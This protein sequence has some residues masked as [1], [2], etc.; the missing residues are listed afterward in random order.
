MRV[1]IVA[2]YVAL[3]RSAWG[4]TEES[5]EL[6]K[7]GVCRMTR[8]TPALIHAWKRVWVPGGLGANRDWLHCRVSSGCRV[9]RRIK[10]VI[11]ERDERVYR[12]GYTANSYLNVLEEGFI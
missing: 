2:C 6:R 7:K 11:M 8:M 5:R 12:G 3:R 4:K 10:L 1:A 9:G